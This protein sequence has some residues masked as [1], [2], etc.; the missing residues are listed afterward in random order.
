MT[1]LMF[2]LLILCTFPHMVVADEPEKIEKVIVTG[3][4]EDAD[5]ARQN[6]I[7]N[8]VEQVVGTYVSADTMVK[9]S[10]L[11]ND[12]ILSFSGGFVKES[13]I[14]STKKIDDTVEIELEAL[15][16]STKLK[17]KIG[18]LN[19]TVKKVDGESLF[20]EAITRVTV[21]KSGNEQLSKILSKF[22]H[23]AYRVELGKPE[24]LS[25][26]SSNNI[27]KVK[28]N[29]KISFDKEFMSELENVLK[30]I[31]TK[32]YN[33]L[34]I[35][36]DISRPGEYYKWIQT[37]NA[38]PD[39]EP[40]IMFMFTTNNMLLRGIASKA[41]MV[42]VGFPDLGNESKIIHHLTKQYNSI[43][44]KL[45][46]ELLDSSGNALGV[47]S[48]QVTDDASNY[49]GVSNWSWSSNFSFPYPAEYNAPFIMQSK[50]GSRLGGSR[51]TR[52][53][54][55]LF[56]QGKSIE[57]DISFEEDI[58]TLKGVTTMRASFEPYIVH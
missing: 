6:A 27:A 54:D 58:L 1:K 13:R 52:Y 20:G 12:E 10:A 3:I 2:I 42:N 36:F 15:V 19:I 46:I 7:R 41:Y 24:I 50:N 53:H 49:K 9:D 26:N 51:R 35:L 30:T 17:R 18:E 39:D 45:K 32:Q 5:K 22:P 57:F 55:L 4:G 38:K 44:P 23:A 28:L 40:V 48:T 34:D 16:V 33:A 56:I 31:S 14:L 29:I 43:A 47:V 37:M 11:I 25:V 21:I 8:A